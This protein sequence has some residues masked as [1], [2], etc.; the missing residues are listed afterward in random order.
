M[1]RTIESKGRAALVVLVSVAS[2]GVGL[3]WVVKPETI[4]HYLTGYPA[5]VWMSV[6]LGLG[7]MAFSVRAIVR[8]MRLLH[9]FVKKRQT[10]PKREIDIAHKRKAEVEKL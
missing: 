2:F 10:T 1:D 8:E 7:I 5:P 4:R 3:W 6:L 9:G